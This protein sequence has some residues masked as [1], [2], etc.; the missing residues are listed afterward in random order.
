[1]VSLNAY[2]QSL[3]LFKLTCLGINK[4]KKDKFEWI[5]TIN[6]NLSDFVYNYNQK[7][8]N[9]FIFSRTEKSVKPLWTILLDPEII[10]VDYYKF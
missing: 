10:A 9:K 4:L 2:I 7:Q 6:N 3:D 5:L 1:M 8:R